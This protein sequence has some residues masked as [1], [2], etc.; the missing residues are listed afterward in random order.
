MQLMETPLEYH[1][2]TEIHQ[3]VERFLVD[4]HI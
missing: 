3:L 4:Q 1:C 2:F